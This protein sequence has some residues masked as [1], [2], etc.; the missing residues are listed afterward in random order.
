MFGLSEP[1]TPGTHLVSNSLGNHLVSHMPPLTRRQRAFLLCCTN[2]IPFDVWVFIAGALFFVQDVCC[3]KQVCKLFDTEFIR[4]SL[5]FRMWNLTRVPVRIPASHTFGMSHAERAWHGVHLVAVRK[6]NHPMHSSVIILR[7][8]A[9]RAIGR[10]KD[11]QNIYHQW[12]SRFHLLVE[13]ASS[14]NELVVGC[15]GR[16][17]VVGQNGACVDGRHIRQGGSFPI[18]HHTDFELVMSTGIGYR[19]EYI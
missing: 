4:A 11:G 16:V 19:V 12:V 17:N 5:D 6:D 1:N 7:D 15:M 2:V 10:L 14:P 9:T 18:Y 8:D 13:L 3:M